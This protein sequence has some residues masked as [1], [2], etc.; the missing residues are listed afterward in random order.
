MRIG[1]LC[2]KFKEMSST[3]NQTT[4]LAGNL[5]TEINKLGSNKKA[6]MAK[7]KAIKERARMVAKALSLV[8][9]QSIKIK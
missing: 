3:F 2:H 1:L 9:N 7:V 5:E 4:V 8:N 6:K